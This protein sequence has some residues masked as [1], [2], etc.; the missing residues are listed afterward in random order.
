MIIGSRM[1]PFPLLSLFFSIAS[2]KRRKKEV[3]APRFSMEDPRREEWRAREKEKRA[4]RERGREGGKRKRAPRGG[5]LALCL[6][7]HGGV[8]VGDWN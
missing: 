3:E 8:M 5:I 2:P 4:E 6:M 7:L 1:L